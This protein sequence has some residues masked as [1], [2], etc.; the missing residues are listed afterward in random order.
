MIILGVDPGTDS[1]GYAIIEHSNNVIKIIEHGTV[2]TKEWKSR[3]II[4]FLLETDAFIKQQT[5]DH[6]ID[7]FAIER[8]FAIHNPLIS[9]LLVVMTDVMK[10]SAKEY[11][12]VKIKSFSVKEWRKLTTQN[13]AIT[14]AK[15]IEYIQ[16]M[17]P[18]EKFES[19]DEIEALGIAYAGIIYQQ[20]SLTKTQPIVRRKSRKKS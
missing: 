9:P 11:D 10:E 8:T 16:N 15:C 12:S 19:K 5:E 2:H 14:K 17:F 1:M 18:S 7:F 4:G 13:G 20:N 3:S 6:G